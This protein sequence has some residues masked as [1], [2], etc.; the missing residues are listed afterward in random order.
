M[1]TINK[2]IL[3]GNISKDPLVYHMQNGRMRVQFLLATHNSHKTPNGE[4][5]THTDW[6]EVIFWSP[7]AEEVAQQVSKGRSVYVEGKLHYRSYLDK[8]GQRQSVAQI[9][10]HQ[11]VGLDHL[12]TQAQEKPVEVVNQRPPEPANIPDDIDELPW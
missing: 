6:H 8:S 9:I 12:K 10:G 4:Q 11:L 7:Y 3:L 1:S 2:V 5:I